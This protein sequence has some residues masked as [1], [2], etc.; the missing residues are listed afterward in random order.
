MTDV[1]AIS[2]SRADLGYLLPVVRRLGDRCEVRHL[3]GFSPAGDSPHQIAQ[4][5]GEAI[6]A[7][8]RLLDAPRL[9]LLCGDRW[10]TAAAAQA[11]VLHGVPI[12]HI[13]GGA[14]TS[15]S[16]DGVFRDQVTR[17]STLHLCFTEREA[18]RVGD[19]AGPAI[20]VVTGSPALSDLPDPMPEPEERYDAVVLLRPETARAS[21]LAPAVAGALSEL[22]GLSSLWLGGC[23]DVGSVKYGHGGL[24]REEYLRVLAHAS[25]VVGN[26]SSILLEAPFFGTPGVLVGD[27]QRGRQVPSS[28]IEVP[29]RARDIR[30]AIESQLVVGRYRPDYTYGFGDGADRIASII[31]E[32]L[33]A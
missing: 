24:D 22:V 33:D 16:Y 1:L 14:R 20:T 23:P 18:Q 10:E 7:A 13:G 11:C 25:V 27:R 9:V 8:S 17:A 28:V 19:V 5:M 12:A 4:A 2:G 3:G 26:S 6:E 30:E 31:K 32:W 29:A 15:G 21:W